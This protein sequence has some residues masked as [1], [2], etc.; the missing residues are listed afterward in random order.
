VRYSP[1]DVVSVAVI[2]RSIVASIACLAHVR[3]WR[4]RP[5]LS[6]MLIMELDHMGELKVNG[7]ISTAKPSWVG[8][9]PW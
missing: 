3:N 1:F 8:L 4:V 9:A 6:T 2:L 7:A 5:K